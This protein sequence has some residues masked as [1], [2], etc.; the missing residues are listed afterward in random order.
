MD[1]KGLPEKE[2]PIVLDAIYTSPLLGPEDK[3]VKRMLAETQALLGAGTETTGNTLSVLT[4]HVLSKPDILKRLKSEL[5]QAAGRMSS[6]RALMDCRALEPLP[7]LQACIKEALRLATGVCSRLPRSSRVERKYY[8]EG[9]ALDGTRFEFPRGTVVSMSILDL[10]YNGKIFEA[11]GTFDPLRWLESDGEKLQKMEKA[12]AP[13]G[14]GTRQCIGLDLAK[15][16]LLLMAGN[17]FHRFDLELYQ[18]TA[19]DVS[20]AH[21]Y[22]APFG[23]KDSKGVRV[24]VK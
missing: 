12:F 19:R 20:I 3:T 18:T 13:F 14:R 17:L 4:Y 23:P 9:S 22:F 21:D 5:S 1:R 15:S 8:G 24:T 16:E 10:H 6:S 7:Y 11:P 2:Q